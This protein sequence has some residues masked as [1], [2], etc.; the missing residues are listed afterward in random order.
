M[1]FKYLVQCNGCGAHVITDGGDLD[2]QL[3]CDPAAIAA[4]TCCGQD[5]H[6]A[7][8]SEGAVPCRPVTI[9]AVSEV[10]AARVESGD[11]TPQAML[12]EAGLA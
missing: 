10:M 1:A 7:Q 4:G 3:D 11:Q 12:K 8:A 5:H 9:S 2:A 6:H